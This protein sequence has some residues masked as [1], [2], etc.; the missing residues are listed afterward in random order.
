MMPYRL[1]N[2]TAIEGLHRS[3]GGTRVV[4]FDEAV[5]VTFAV[6]L[7]RKLVPQEVL[8]A[9]VRVNTRSCRG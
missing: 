5:V 2:A 3:F 9:R 7:L 1:M 4:E 8:H 6:K